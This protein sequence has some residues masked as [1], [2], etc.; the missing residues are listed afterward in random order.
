MSQPEFVNMIHVKSGR[1]V[2]VPIDEV[3]A[4]VTTSNIT[5]FLYTPVSATIKVLD[6]WN[7]NL[8]TVVASGAFHA[9]LP[10]TKTPRF[11]P[12]E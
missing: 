6:K 5:R 1:V 7:G 4:A 2:R 8:P 10:G 11:I 9:R 3:H 12:I